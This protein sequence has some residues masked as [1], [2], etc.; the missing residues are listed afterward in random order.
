MLP[1][2]G[3]VALSGDQL[4]K[5]GHTGTLRQMSSSCIRLGLVPDMLYE[6]MDGDRPRDRAGAVPD[7]W[8]PVDAKLTEALSTT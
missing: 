5:V 1:G 4:N 3:T 8:R 7:R 6:S 2:L